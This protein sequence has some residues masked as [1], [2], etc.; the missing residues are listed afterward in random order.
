MLLV[1][2]TGGLS[3]VPRPY[4][5]TNRRVLGK[6]PLPDKHPCTTFQGINVA[7]PIQM[8][9]TCILGKHHEGWNH[10]LCLS[11]HGHFTQDTT[12]HAFL[13]FQCCMLKISGWLGDDTNIEKLLIAWAGYDDNTDMVCSQEVSMHTYPGCN[14]RTGCLYHHRWDSN[15]LKYVPSSLPSHPLD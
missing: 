10:E 4:Y 15:S 11:M 13:V 1:L 8:Y 5:N 12:V 6:R 3:H 7:V 2:Y 14:Q 9:A